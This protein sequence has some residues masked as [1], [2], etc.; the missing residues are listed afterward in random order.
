MHVFPS[1]LRVKGRRASGE[2]LQPASG[3]KPSAIPFTVRFSRTGSLLERSLSCHVVIY[4][5]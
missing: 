1:T 4:S 2:L 3:P 5:P